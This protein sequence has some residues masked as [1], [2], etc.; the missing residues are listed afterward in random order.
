[1]LAKISSSLLDLELDLDLVSTE[2]K[3]S[4]FIEAR[5]AKTRADVAEGDEL[6]RAAVI[7]RVCR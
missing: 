5:H 6:V 1:M 2:A 3:E 4:P 7:C